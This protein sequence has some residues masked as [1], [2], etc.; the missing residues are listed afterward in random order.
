MKTNKKIVR[1]TRASSGIGV[2]M[3][4]IYSRRGVNLTLSTINKNKL[5]KVKS[6]CTYFQNIKILYFDLT[7]SKNSDT[8]VQ[9]AL[10]LFEGID[11]LINNAWASLAKDH[12]WLK[13]TSNFLKNCWILT[14]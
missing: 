4:K 12:Y 2:A 7:I 13:Q 6:K 11:V 3:A 5:E 1:I 9:K 10:E 14:F 8:M